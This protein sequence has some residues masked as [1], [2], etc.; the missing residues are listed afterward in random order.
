MRN[1]EVGG[2][3][4]ISHTT[5]KEKLCCLGRMSLCFGA[6]MGSGGVVE[7][8]DTHPRPRGGGLR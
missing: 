7:G 4:T 2:T 5:R 6:P 3:A 1:L 8:W